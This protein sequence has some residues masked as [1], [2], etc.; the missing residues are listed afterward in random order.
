MTHVAGRT[1]LVTGAG[2]GIG[3][4]VALD[5]ARRG[6]RLVLWDVDAEALTSVAKEI[7]TAGGE[8][9]A[10]QCDVGDPDDVTRAAA[11][12]RADA[13][14]VDVLVNNAGVVS[15]RP[16]MELTQQDIERTFRV[17]ILAHFW[18]TRAFL[19]DM[20][21]RDAGHVVTVASVAGL[22]GGPRVADYAASKHAAVGFAE[23]LRMELAETAPG[24][25]TTLVCPWFVDTGMFEGARTRWPLLL[26]FLRPEDVAARVVKAILRDQ[27]FLQ[28][29]PFVR[30]LPLLK[31]LPTPMYDASLAFFGVTHAMDEF[32]GREN[33]R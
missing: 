3:R 31:M 28:M 2:S 32:V 9:F 14:P 15:G 22:G 11:L 1:A 17:N 4:L 24:V 10:Y 18:T 27:A 8:A 29:P 7:R 13:G 20:V 30:V 5:L 12:V 26:P 6:A 16:L 33:R 21:E 19:P 23:S 25:R